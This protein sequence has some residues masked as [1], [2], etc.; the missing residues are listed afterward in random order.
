MLVLCKSIVEFNKNFT[1]ILK[2]KKNFINK[3][4][5]NLFNN[6]YY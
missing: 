6:L 5:I 4:L 1:N 3:Q 2:E